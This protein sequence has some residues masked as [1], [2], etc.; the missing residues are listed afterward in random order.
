MTL[1][2][3]ANGKSPMKT[4]ALVLTYTGAVWPV[5]VAGGALIPRFKIGRVRER[6]WMLFFLI[7]T[8][9]LVSGLL[10]HYSFL[11]EEHPPS[12]VTNYGLMGSRVSL[13]TVM[14]ERWLLLGAF[15]TL[16]EAFRSR[17]KPNRWLSGRPIRYRW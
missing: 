4:F 14:M 15:V 8:T 17:L 3:S 16:V 1:L 11:V 6:S 10:L 9:V 12:H 13:G 5:F 7:Y 2:E